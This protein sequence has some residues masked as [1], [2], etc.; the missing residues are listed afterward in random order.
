LFSPKLLCHFFIYV[1]YSSCF[2][3]CSVISYME[4]LF[5]FS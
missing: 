5:C 3:N 4:Q 2:T 1:L